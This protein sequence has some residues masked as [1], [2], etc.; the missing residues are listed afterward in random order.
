VEVALYADTGS[1]LTLIEVQPTP[2]TLDAGER[3]APMT[4]V[5]P[6]AVYESGEMVA[7]IDDDGTGVGSHN[8]CE[9]GNNEARWGDPVCE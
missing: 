9:E 8:E 1:G 5:V 4:F 6:L 3:L 2:T 7:A